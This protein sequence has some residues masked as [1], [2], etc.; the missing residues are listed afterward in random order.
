MEVVNALGQDSLRR[1]VL[2]AGIDVEPTWLPET[3]ST[4]D[5]ALRMADAG[6]PEWT[7]VAT[8]HQTAGRGRLGRS[9][10]DVPGSSLLFSTILRPD[11]TPERAPLITLLAA[12]AM[13]EAAG[14]PSLRSK[15]PNDLV[16]ADRKIGGILA[17]AATADGGVRHVVIGTGLNIAASGLPGDRGSSSVG[18]EGGEPDADGILARYLLAL[19]AEYDQ[20]DFPDR[21]VAR[22]ASVCSTLGRKVRATSVGGAVVEGLARELDERGSLLVET[23]EGVHT[24]A[25]GEVIHLRAT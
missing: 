6:A 17:E 20:I 12:T 15:W 10:S 1:A 7:V 18:A 23:D 24:I 14:L 3:T 16:V 4:N 19:K 5:E 11:L 22:Y 2:A 8:A 13:V 25:F 9:W 21:V